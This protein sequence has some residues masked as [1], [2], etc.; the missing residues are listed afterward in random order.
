MP[1]IVATLLTF[2]FIFLA[3]RHIGKQDKTTS[4]AAW[5]PTIW[6]SILA[7]K[8]VAAWLST[9]VY[10][11]SEQSIQDGSAADRNL[12]LAL[13][14]IALVTITKRNV[15]LSRIASAN[16]W[17]AAL[18]LFSAASILWSDYPFVALKRWVR[19]LGALLIGSILF[20]ER[21]PSEAIKSVCLRVGLVLVPLSL[22]TIKYI[23]EIGV[24]YNQWTGDRALRGV[25]NDKN[26][27]G[28]LAWISAIVALWALQSA[29]RARLITFTRAQ[30]P[31][32]MLL[33]LS[34]LILIDVSSATSLLC[35][36]V[37]IL[38]YFFSRVRLIQDRPTL[39][40]FS[41]LSA[42]LLALAF[43]ASPTMR[44]PITTIL[45]RSPDLTERTVIWETVIPM[46]ENMLFGHGFAS[47]WLSPPAR[48]LGSSLDITSA[49]NGFLETYLN[50]GIV[51]LGLMIVVLLLALHRST[52][53]NH[54]RSP[55][56]PFFLS[57]LTASILY[58]FSES[59]LNGFSSIG[60]LIWIISIAPTRQIS[61]VD[62]ARSGHGYSPSQL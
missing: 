5:V 29:P 23:P 40:F 59:A 43:L 19:D 51:G 20:S 41:L 47:F 42:L 35:L 32:L 45:N 10:A 30:W 14:V 13:M 31:Q 26:I 33:F 46:Q 8:P 28:R 62:Q 1:P 37:G 60:M 22:L 6:T 54:N 15:S 50:L 36:A 57:I 12:L 49:H 44:K 3:L 7:S 34:L 48:A 58:N 24:Y 39:L 17:L 61:P 55:L 11:Q 4:F 53:L 52:T 56:G 21:N 16:L 27:L 38:V 18:F 9:G 25:T 2:G